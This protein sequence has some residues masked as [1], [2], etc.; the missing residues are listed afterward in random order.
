MPWTLR[1]WWL[2]DRA[3]F[4]AFR[5]LRAEKPGEAV[6][7]FD[8]VLAIFPKH[9]RA[10]AQRALALA[11]AGH[12]GQA[13]NA[14]RR[15][16]ELD[17]GNHAPLLF[18]G[19]IHFD[20][21][22]FEEARKA[23]SAALRL[24]PDNRMVK[25][26]LGLTQVAQG[27]LAEGAEGLKE[28]LAYGYEGLEARLITLAEQYLWQRRDQA[29]PLEQQLTAEEG[30]GE[31]PPAGL[32][33]KV[34]SLVRR[35]LLWPL[36]RVRGRAALQLMLAHEAASLRDHEAAIRHLREAEKLGA[37]PERF[38]LALGEAYLDAG[39]PAAA[40]E[41]L[42]RLPERTRKQ[43]GV[44]LVF[45]AALFDAGRYDEAREYIAIAAERFSRD[46]APPYYRGLC[47][48]ALGNPKA[49]LP[50]FLKTAG[51][52]NPQIAQKRLEEMVRV[53]ALSAEGS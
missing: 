47:E 15:A 39:N 6:K 23:F 2:A 29:R 21:G 27:R 3:Y 10:H 42:A 12:V 46:F 18:L 41:Q 17:P 31:E 44:A 40:A 49:A 50:W 32:G 52:L 11:A 48:M 24:D 8:E 36:A 43:P 37:K 4:R 38:A 13:V 28:H 25:A 51:R 34:A 19:R 14:A 5:L 22:N 1:N 45:G 33:L 30:G 7:S 53:H 20:A 26:Y 16:A 9:A 35:A